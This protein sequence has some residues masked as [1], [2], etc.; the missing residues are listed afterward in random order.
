MDVIIHADDFGIEPAQSARILECCAG[1]AG[2]SCGEKGDA[3]KGA[4]GQGGLLNSLSIFANSPRFEDC[5]A[6]LDARPEG[7]RLGVHLNFVEI[8]RAHV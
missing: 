7:L 5:A 1:V 4:A 8:G 3:E 6:L 2:A